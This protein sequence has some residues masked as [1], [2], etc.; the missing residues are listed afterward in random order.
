MYLFIEISRTFIL[1]QFR[2]DVKKPAFTCIHWSKAANNA[3]PGTVGWE[4]HKALNNLMGKLFSKKC[5]YI[6]VYAQ[7]V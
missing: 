6:T 3:T 2:E 1:F 5:V 7:N 4:V